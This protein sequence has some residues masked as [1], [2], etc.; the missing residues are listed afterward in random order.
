MSLN[1]LKRGQGVGNIIFQGI[2]NGFPIQIL[3]DGGNLDNFLQPRLAKFLKLGVEPSHNI[4]VTIG[5]GTHMQAEGKV[6]DIIVNVQGSVSHL[7][8]SY[9]YPGLIQFWE[10]PG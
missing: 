5:D 6:K 10:G 4:E 3:G 1:T 7:L 2:L 9:L 8:V